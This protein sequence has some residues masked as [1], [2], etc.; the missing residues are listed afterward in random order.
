MKKRISFLLALVLTALA[1]TAC[2][3]GAAETSASAGSSPDASAPAEAAEDNGH[4]Y[5]AAD[6]EGV[7]TLDGF[8][9]VQ[10]SA[11]IDLLAAVD[12]D[13]TVVT[14][15]S[16]A[17]DGVSYELAKA[18]AVTYIITVNKAAL[19]E[20]LG[21]MSED[22]DSSEEITIEVTRRVPVVA[23]ANCERFL[24]LNPDMVLL[25]DGNTAYSPVV[26]QGTEP[27][28]AVANE[29]GAEVPVEEE[30]GTPGE[31]ADPGVSGA[32][33]GGNGSETPSG[34]SGTGTSGNGGGSSN[35]ASGAGTS[36][37]GAGSGGN[38]G[39][40]GSSGG[41]G[42][43]GN[44]SDN[45]HTN[46]S[47]PTQTTTPSGSGSGSSNNSQPVHT[48][49]WKDVTEEKWV[50]DQAAYDEPVYEYRTICNQCG[51][52]ITGAVDVHMV[53]AIESGGGCYSYSAR[54]IQV[55]TTH[56]DEVGHYETVVTGSVCT[57]CGA[58]MS[59]P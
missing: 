48:H 28:D 23:P 11:D 39:G 56:H 51:A 57:G 31:A 5:T 43:G 29:G 8:G 27:G 7:V 58:T 34:G 46:T 15:M 54:Q 47:T 33:S 9:V 36:S 50:V 13:N 30:N 40:T 19:D 6:L 3:A 35:P 21:I 24:A 41:S 1:L 53:A 16:V 2:G 10:G 22:G 49:T 14:N 25:T 45:Q 20:R 38:G 59:M 52:D 18:Q 4:E 55:G 17:A 42:S 32:D 37:G 12:Y 44:G 26:D